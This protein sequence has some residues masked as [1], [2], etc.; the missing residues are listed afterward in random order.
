MAGNLGIGI[1]AFLS[2]L[3]QGAQTY[4]NISDQMSRSKLRDAQVKELEQ[5]AADK[6]QGRSIMRAGAQQA[7]TARQEDIQKAV[8]AGVPQDQAESQVGSYL[9]YWK[10]TTAPQLVQHWMETGDVDKAQNFDKWLEDS[11]VQQ[12]MKSWANMSRSFAMGDRAGFLKNLNATL[13]QSGYY[14]G[15]IQPLE[16]TEKVNDK[17]QLTGYTVRFK[18]KAT[19]KESTQ[20]YDGNDI[21]KMAVVG[22]SPQQIYASGVDEIKAARAAR[23]AAVKTQDDRQWDVQKMGIQ[24]QNTLEGQAN[25]SQLRMAEASEKKRLGIGDSSK[26]PL[27]KAKATEQY[28][29]DKGYS[30]DY[31][32]KNAPALVGIQNQNKPRASRIEDFIKLQTENDRTFNKLPLAQQI[33]QANSYIDTVDASTNGNISEDTPTQ[34][35]QPAQQQQQGRRIFWDNNTKSVFQR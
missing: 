10:K 27:A 26:D 34:T 32:K 21:Q 5:N 17:G 4:S 24:Q 22:L 7:N 14:D 11:N 29:R 2:G 35:Q 1:G 33:E 3:S 20:D 25:Q 23:A 9:D 16:A 12:G 19:G 30:D 28:L 6:Q 8:A 15:N 18:D 31:I 13:T